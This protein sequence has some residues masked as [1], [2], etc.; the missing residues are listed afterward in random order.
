MED[1][2]LFI[3]IGVLM[4]VG[5]TFREGVKALRSGTVEKTVKGSQE[6]LIIPRHANPGV[7]WSYVTAYFGVAVGALI[8]GIWLLFV[9]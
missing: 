1:K 7:Y 5:W 2:A 9:K 3:V 6:P 4:V 8:V